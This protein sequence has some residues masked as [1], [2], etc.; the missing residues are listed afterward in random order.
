MTVN[1]STITVNQRIHIPLKFVHLN[2][3]VDIVAVPG[4]NLTR[5]RSDSVLIIE[6]LKDMPN[7]S[8]R[9]PKP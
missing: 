3:F 6:I 9:T 5:D 1:S 2:P 4:S 7:G 8:S